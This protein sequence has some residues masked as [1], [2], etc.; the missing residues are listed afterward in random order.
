MTTLGIAIPVWSR[1]ASTSFWSIALATSTPSKPASC[2]NWNFSRTV[3]FC[4]VGPPSVASMKPFFSARRFTA[5]GAAE[6]APADSAPARAKGAIAAAAPAAQRKFRR[7]MA[8]ANFVCPGIAR[9]A[10]VR[11]MVQSSFSGTRTSFE[12]SACSHVTAR[13]V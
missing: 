10:T 6:A 4:A 5:I 11:A 13:P 2:N 3:S 12:L 7:F 1:A 8:Q 9:G